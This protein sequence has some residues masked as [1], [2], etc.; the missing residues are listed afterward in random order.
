MQVIDRL[1]EILTQKG[2]SVSKFSNESGIPSGRVYKW[3]DENKPVSP[4]HEDVKKIEEWIKKQ[5]SRQ[6][7][8]PDMRYTT[9]ITTDRRST[10]AAPSEN[11]QQI[12]DLKSEIK[13][14][15]ERLAEAESANK[16]L[17]SMLANSLQKS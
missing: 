15:R 16:E 14:L 11:N 1:N 10:I 3:F 7:P 17:R 9:P 8:D 2:I 5:V 4:K 12:E 13:W 6:E